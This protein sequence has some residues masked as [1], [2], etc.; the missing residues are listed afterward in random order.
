MKEL[1]Q[2]LV[3]LIMASDFATSKYSSTKDCSLA[4]A[5]KRA[6]AVHNIPFTDNSI[7]IGAYHADILYEGK[8][9]KYDISFQES[10]II[11]DRTGLSNQPPLDLTLKLRK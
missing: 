6:L 5:F 9:Q 8:W 11:V 1:P 7:S 10:K 2:T 4:K 3:T